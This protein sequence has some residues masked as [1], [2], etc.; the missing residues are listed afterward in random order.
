[1][2]FNQI[3]PI[4]FVVVMYLLVFLFILSLGYLVVR[5][6]VRD[7]IMDARAR[8]KEL[9]E[10]WSPADEADAPPHAQN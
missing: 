5:R 7:G 2:V 8:V 6:A 4:L 3:I 9:E 10:P 1:M